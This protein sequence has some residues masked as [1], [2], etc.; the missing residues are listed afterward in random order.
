VTKAITQ[1]RYGPPDAL[2]F[3]DVDE[4]VPGD[5]DL[6]IRVHAASLSAAVVL[7]LRGVPAL[8]RLAFGLRRPK[9]RVPGMDV[10]GTVVAGRGVQRRQAGSRPFDRSGSRH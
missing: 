7:L 2:R 5:D 6:L 1:D 10:A 3:S 4:P 9:A 8:G